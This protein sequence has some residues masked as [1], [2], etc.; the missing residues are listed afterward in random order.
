V[1][2]DALELSIVVEGRK[3]F[4]EVG[5]QRYEAGSL[6]ALE[7]K[8]R[9]DYD[10][11]GVVFMPADSGAREL[12]ELAQEL[13]YNLLKAQD[14]V[15]RRRGPILFKLWRDYGLSVR[16]IALVVGHISHGTVNKLI[17]EE[18]ERVHG[19]SEGNG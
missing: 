4:A 15:N 11:E 12:V 14:E 5:G 8:V 2:E 13:H 3:V 1:A 16:D 10:V 18:K 17:L 9:E 6:P 7:A 19:G